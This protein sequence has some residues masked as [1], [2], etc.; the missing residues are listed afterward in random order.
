[1]VCHP[2]TEVG[3]DPYNLLP[4]LRLTLISYRDSYSCRKTVPS[5]IVSLSK[6]SSRARRGVN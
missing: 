6:W 3:S 1:M 4:Q 5:V 2:V